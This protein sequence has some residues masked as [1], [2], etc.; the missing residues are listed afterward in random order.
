MTNIPTTGDRDAGGTG[1]APDSRSTS[2]SYGTLGL[3]CAAPYIAMLWS[4]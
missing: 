4:R 3:L 1:L 2:L